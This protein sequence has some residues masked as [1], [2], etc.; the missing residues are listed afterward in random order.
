ML[1]AVA[2]AVAALVAATASVP[3]FLASTGSAAVVIQAGERCPSETGVRHESVFRV[4][5]D[6]AGTGVPGGNGSGGEIPEL[7]ADGRPRDH[8]PLA[9]LRGFESTEFE[10]STPGRVGHK[11]GMASSGVVI[12]S[13]DDALDHVDIVEEGAGPGLW[14]SDRLA[15][16]SDLA[17]GDDVE[18]QVLDL[19]AEE[20]ARGRTTTT[21]DPLT[22][23]LPVAGIYR[24]LSDG[25]GAEV[26]YWCWNSALLLPP[27]AG[28][29][30]PD[31]VVL[32]DPTT[33]LSLLQQAG[34]S[35]TVGRWL[36]R[37]DTSGLDLENAEHIA[38]DLAC[39]TELASH[40][41]WCRG[42]SNIDGELSWDTSVEQV[43]GQLPRRTRPYGGPFSDDR[44]IPEILELGDEDLFA[45]R[46]LGSHLPFVTER[47]EAI[48]RSVSG[49]VQPV[50][51][52]AALAAAGL[53]A[54]AG[55]LWFDRRRR[56]LHLL[57]VRGVS[58]AALGVKAVLELLPALVVGSLLGWAAAHG[59]VVWLGPS[60]SLGAGSLRSA[61]VTAAITAI[62]AGAVVGL[63]AGIRVRTGASRRRHR[64]WLVWLPWELGLG[65]AT[66]VAFQRL[67]RWAVP[68][69]QGADVTTIDTLGLL[70][71][72]LF[73]LT[74][75]AIVT[76]IAVLL[77]PRLRRLTAGSRPAL[78]LAVRRIDR[79]RP[80]ALGL[81][82]AAA[83]ATGVLGYSATLTQSL[84]STLD[85]KATA[86]VGADA[87]FRTPEP[88]RVSASLSEP[89][90]AVDVYRLARIDTG[91]SRIGGAVLALDPETFR[92]AA[93]WDS[94]FANR[95]LEA[96]L[97]ELATLRDDGAIPAV[98]V[99]TDADQL[100]DVVIQ[101]YRSHRFTVRP[102]PGVTAFPGMRREPTVIV[103][104]AA[105]ERIGVSTEHRLG[106]P[107]ADTEIWVDG[108][109]DDT[110]AVLAADG[111]SFDEPRTVGAMVDRTSF[112]TVSWAFGYMRSVGITAGLL[113]M[114]G[115]AV[116]LDARRRS[117]VL[118]YAFARRMGLTSGHHRRAL[119]TELLLTVTAGCWLGLII[120]LAGAWLAHGSMDPVPNFAPPPLLRPALSLTGATAALAA[121]VAVAGSVLA[122]RRVDRDD[123][124]EVLRG[125]I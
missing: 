40:L 17:P 28:A 1:V 94:S 51:G 48:Q 19:S 62:V 31:P 90:T 103:D 64:R 25:L 112:L 98:V 35:A 74:T 95:S 118:G 41:Q 13:R 16:A 83:V 75:I 21:A 89:S 70:F 59:L 43:P 11:D 67:G 122:Q 111:V 52:L 84:H 78:F 30:P 60:A 113:T 91:S 7:G 3:L 44:G 106:I 5:G 56:E 42:I 8:A 121:V 33:H 116:Y 23:T 68:V 82:A 9:S 32:A 96:V 55:S 114:T 79:Q 100:V 102:L 105:L 119:L 104:R 69:S 54:A 108:D 93:F 85:A 77:L 66:V 58:P 2:G 125:G 73:L 110:R 65:A 47:A 76:R 57:T 22:A 97:D 61:G 34:R 72:L 36:A 27:A 80:A 117:Q 18:V 115:L 24:D 123:P 15:G 87:A 45:S 99:R 49:G 4:P 81:V 26:D 38:T 50:A 88:G 6:G 92:R 107:L 12:L 37:L 14:I 109:P 86:F 46:E 120:A 29:D 39:G 63:V 124:V 101:G 71:P 53:V 10:L 20:L